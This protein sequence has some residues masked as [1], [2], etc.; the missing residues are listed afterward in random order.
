MVCSRA[1]VSVNEDM[2]RSYFP[3]ARPGRMLSNGAFS[4]RTGLPSTWPSALA[5][6][7]SSPMIVLL[8]SAKNSFGGYDASAAITISL[9]LPRAGGRV[10]AAAL[11][12][13]GTPEAEGRAAVLL[14]PELEPQPASV[15]NESA[16]AAVLTA[17]VRR[18]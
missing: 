8:S 7:T 14:P 3:A 6:S 18:T 15:A 5:R 11:V 9:L 4:K 12:A 17:T 10:I 1:L 2:P 16:A 13:V